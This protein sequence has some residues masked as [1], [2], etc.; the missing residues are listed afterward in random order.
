MPHNVERFFLTFQLRKQFKSD[1]FASYSVLVNIV[2]TPILL[3]PEGHYFG[4]DGYFGAP[5]CCFEQPSR[6]IA[7]D[8]TGHSSLTTDISHA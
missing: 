8:I 5:P 2:N 1:F 6:S 4:S 3:I 7:R